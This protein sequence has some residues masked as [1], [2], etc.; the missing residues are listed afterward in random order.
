LINV[1]YNLMLV[2]VLKLF[3]HFIINIHIVL[4]FTMMLTIKKFT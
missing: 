1:V 3:D 4:F 2:I